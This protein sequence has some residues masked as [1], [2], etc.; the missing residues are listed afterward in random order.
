MVAS[1]K[2][3]SSKGFHLG[4][5]EVIELEGQSEKTCPLCTR[6]HKTE[7]LS[8]A[9]RGFDVKSLSRDLPQ[10]T[11]QQVVT[12]VVIGVGTS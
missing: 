5:A 7:S 8:K 3:R 6:L 2:L 12:N 9:K 1:T 4:F 10:G 11:A